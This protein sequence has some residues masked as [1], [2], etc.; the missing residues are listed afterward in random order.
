M[1]F[2]IVPAEGERE[3]EYIGV[4]AFGWKFIPY[5][6]VNTRKNMTYSSFTSK[7]GRCLN[8]VELLRWYVGSEFDGVILSSENFISKLHMHNKW[9][10]TFRRVLAAVWRATSPKFPV[11]AMYYAV[12]DWI[13]SRPRGQRVYIFHSVITQW[14][15]QICITNLL[16][17]FLFRMVI[18]SGGAC[19]KIER[20]L[21]F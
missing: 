12:E 21:S 2:E 1:L 10:N 4:L 6:R 13:R 11:C 15:Y 14:T 8:L 3:R 18:N 16:H 7:L 9:C 20:L 17:E 19:S 5:S